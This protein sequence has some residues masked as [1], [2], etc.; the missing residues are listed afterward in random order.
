MFNCPECD[1][2]YTKQTSLNRHIQNHLKSKQYTC[3]TCHVSFYRRDL[4]SRHSKMH[5]TGPP[6][7]KSST[8][9]QTQVQN[10]GNQGRQRCHTACI[11]CRESRT[12]C[13]GSRPC[14][15]CASSGRSCEYSR[16][17]NRISRAPL[18]RG[19]VLS[20][21]AL[22]QTALNET[23]ND[24]EAES[25]VLGRQQDWTAQHEESRH[26]YMDLDEP[27]SNGF[28]QSPA[29]SS[30][31]P[32][33]AVDA[34]IEHCR[35]DL[36]GQ[37]FQNGGSNL[38]GLNLSVGMIDPLL[39]DLTSDTMAW[40][41]LHENLFLQADYSEPWPVIHQQNLIDEIPDRYSAGPPDQVPSRTLT[42]PGKSGDEQ[43]LH[44]LYL[45]F[46]PSQSASMLNANFCQ[47]RREVIPAQIAR[48]SSQSSNRKTSEPLR[49]E[50][51][52][53]M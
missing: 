27:Q 35:V 14:L 33:M 17:I 49:D 10:R 53:T 40:P 16:T 19:P 44:N 36:T 50:I 52:L 47:Q 46:A 24:G 45:S 25:T 31:A 12:K 39:S 28:L 6:L 23:P 42:L 11:P 2:G 20:A 34:D 1:K 37:S 26:S 5:N 41:W 48:E 7:P 43:Q 18:H 51:L 30:D 38:D 13:D 32:F 4:L 9:G 8:P 3:P 22:E 29:A 15:S 21:H